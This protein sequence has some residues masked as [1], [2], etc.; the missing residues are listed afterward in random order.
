MARDDTG[1]TPL[2]LAPKE[3]GWT[4]KYLQSYTID[5]LERQVRQL[6][7]KIGKL[8]ESKD[9]SDAEN[10]AQ[11]LHFKETYR[12]TKRQLDTVK[13][14]AREEAKAKARE[15]ERA[16]FESGMEMGYGRKQRESNQKQKVDVPSFC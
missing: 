5:A 10:T 12:L 14:L 7:A 8:E 13:S 9:K 4:R 3:P 6:A 15:E 1:R 16:A 2:Q 11:L